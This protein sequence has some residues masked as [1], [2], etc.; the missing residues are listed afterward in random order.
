MGYDLSAEIELRDV[1]VENKISMEEILTKA[2]KTCF[3]DPFIDAQVQTLSTLLNA[4]DVAWRK[5][6]LSR[7]VY[8]FIFL[9]I[10]FP[11]SSI[12]GYCFIKY[13]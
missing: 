12:S 11:Y 4:F 8:S 6:D 5:E 9:Y 1:G 13:S 2:Y 3:S 10:E 7:L